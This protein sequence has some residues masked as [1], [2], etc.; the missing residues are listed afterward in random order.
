VEPVRVAD[1]VTVGTAA[2]CLGNLQLADGPALTCGPSHG[3]KVP[4]NA[5]AG[6]SRPGPPLEHLRGNVVLNRGLHCRR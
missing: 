4:G 1:L 5:T 2:S 3:A 6:S